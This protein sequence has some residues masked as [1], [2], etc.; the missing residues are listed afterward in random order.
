MVERLSE[1]ELDR[2][3][4]ALGDATRRDILRRTL[5]APV[6][7]HELAAHHAMSVAAVHKHVAVLEEAGLVRKSAAGRERLV[8]GQ[9]QALARA[10]EAL[11]ALESLWRGRLYRL[12]A[13]L[14]P[15]EPEA[16]CPSPSPP[17]PPASR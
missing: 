7:V 12:G 3:F 1:P 15:P 4:K 13:L 11:S 8:H 5:V 16:P 14:T 2:L 10:R 17:T 9:P 6:A